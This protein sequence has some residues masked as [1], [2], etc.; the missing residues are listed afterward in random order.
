MKRKTKINAEAGKQELV[1]TRGFDL[2]LEL[3]FKAYIEP[4]IVEQWMGT[5]VL[6][7][8]NKKHGGYQFET[9]DTNILSKLK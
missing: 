9:I 6:K 3:L 7:L 1:I 8:E 4:D 2:P 5:K